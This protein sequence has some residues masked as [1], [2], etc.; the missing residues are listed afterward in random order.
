VSARCIGSTLQL[1][2]R[3]GGAGYVEAEAV[4]ATEVQCLHRGVRNVGEEEEQRTLGTFGPLNNDGTWGAL[5][6]SAEV[7]CGPLERP[8]VTYHE[9]SVQIDGDELEL[10]AAMHCP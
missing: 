4:G 9:V 6:L 2:F 3:V 7:T 8:T 1:W 10:P 5:T